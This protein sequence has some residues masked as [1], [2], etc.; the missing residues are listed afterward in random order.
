VALGG[1]SSA[2][3]VH[4]AVAAL[5]AGLCTTVIC[6]NGDAQTNR[7]QSRRARLTNW[8]EDFERTYGMISIGS[9]IAL[10]SPEHRGSEF[11]DAVVSDG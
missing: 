10:T 8:V 5:E 1:A 2:A 6:I 7:A 3:M 9:I 11:K 4:N